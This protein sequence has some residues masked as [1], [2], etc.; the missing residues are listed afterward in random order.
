MNK[1][2]NFKPDRMSTVNPYFNGGRRGGAAPVCNYNIRSGVGWW[3]ATHVED[4]NPAE[5]AKRIDQIKKTGQ[6]KQTFK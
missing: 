6:N 2:V 5:Q 3:I 4:L 1:S